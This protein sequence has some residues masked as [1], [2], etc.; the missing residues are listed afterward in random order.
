MCPTPWITAGQASLSITISWSL[1]KLTIYIYHIYSSRFLYYSVLG[2]QNVSSLKQ[3]IKFMWLWWKISFICLY[4]HKKTKK[5]SR[6]FTINKYT[7][8][9][10]PVWLVATLWTAACQA[11]LSF[12]ISLSL[13]KLMSIES[14]MPSNHL[15]VCHPFSSCP[16]FFLAS[17]SFPMSLIFTSR[18][19]SIVAS[20][21]A[22]VLPMN[23]Q[24]WFPLGFTGLISLQS[25]GLSRV[26]FSIIVK[27]HQFFS[28]LPP[29]WFNSH[30][31]TWR[32]EK[33]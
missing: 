24:D 12:T 31:P 29:L 28:A 2:A 30:I 5:S 8:L 25:K 13:L 21:L 15:I 1:S 7:I 33:S 9:F 10:C 3:G 20:T 23:I 19:Q 14:V 16:P 32:L 4:Y 27:K 22:S 11:Y 17:G 18:G 26:F 6:S